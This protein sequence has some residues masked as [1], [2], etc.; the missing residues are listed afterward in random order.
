MREPAEQAVGWRGGVTAGLRRTEVLSRVGGVMSGLSEYV[1][2]SGLGLSD[3]HSLAPRG[4][5]FQPNMTSNAGEAPPLPMRTRWAA[6]VAQF[7]LGIW[8]MRTLLSFAIALPLLLTGCSSSSDQQARLDAM[9]HELCAQREELVRLRAEMS[10]DRQRLYRSVAAIQSGLEDLD[11]TLSLARAEIWGD[12]SSTGSRLSMAERALTSVRT[13]VDDLAR[14][15]G[16]PID[17]R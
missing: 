3:R 12:G 13:K 17:S 7:C 14:L 6:R 16:S 4:A 2:I 1:F 10:G 8:T 11:R 15:A 5:A 9:E